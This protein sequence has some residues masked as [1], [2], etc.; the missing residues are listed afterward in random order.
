MTNSS[1][2]LLLYVAGEVAIGPLAQVLFETSL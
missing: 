2:A 1:F